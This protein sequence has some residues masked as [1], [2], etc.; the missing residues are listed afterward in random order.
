MCAFVHMLASVNAIAYNKRNMAPTHHNEQNISVDT[1]HAKIENGVQKDGAKELFRFII[2]A[3]LVV[4]LIRTYIAS[5]FI[6]SGPSMD[7]TFANGNYLIVDRLSYR[8]EEPER[9][10]IVVFRF[11]LDPS[12]YHIKRVIGLPGETIRVNASGV[13]VVNAEHPDGY[14]LDES[15]ISSNSMPVEDERVL[16]PTE[17]YVL[18]DNRDQSLDSRRTGAVDRKFITGRAFLRLFPFTDIQI[19]PGKSYESVAVR[20]IDQKTP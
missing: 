2:T 18:G 10:D 12:R 11:P 9:G 7:T 20:I 4:F 15:Y 1:S 17:Y 13:Y 5:P 8:F 6:V 16:G 14:K 19:F 3:A